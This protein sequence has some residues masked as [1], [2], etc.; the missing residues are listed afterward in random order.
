MLYLD[1]KQTIKSDDKRF[2]DEESIFWNKYGKIYRY[3]EAGTPYKKMLNE[4]RRLISSTNYQTWFDAGCGP[5]T[6]IELLLNAQPDVR[7][8]IGVDFDGVMIDQASKR[9]SSYSNVDVQQLDL[10]KKLPFDDN[11]FNGVIANLV[12]SYI[13]IYDGQYVGRDALI[14]VLREMYRVLDGNGIFIWTTPIENVNFNK[15]F[16]ASWREVFNPF[17]PQYVFYGPQILSYAL[18]I[19]ARGKMGIYHFLDKDSLL[20]IMKDIGFKSVSITKVFAKQAYL[21][22]A[23][24]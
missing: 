6:M 15:V 8:I 7:K 11:F 17:T 24:K 9:L 3:L 10:A 12:L 2:W 18:K 22:S 23:K 13:I 21:I 20:Q 4:I 14:N 5:G 16:L 19:Q 1:E